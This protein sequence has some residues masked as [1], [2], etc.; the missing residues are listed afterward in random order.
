MPLRDF[1]A[2]DKRTPSSS[3]SSIFDNYYDEYLKGITYGEEQR[4]LTSCARTMQ[5]PKNRRGPYPVSSCASK[6][7]RSIHNSNPRERV[8]PNKF[9]FG[10][11]HETGQMAS[12]SFTMKTVEGNPAKQ[13]TIS[14]DHKDSN[15]K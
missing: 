3:S 1:N 8:A 7:Q 13:R 15:P 5:A 9:T 14:A 2:D 12:S 11:G 4:P 10:F 6:T